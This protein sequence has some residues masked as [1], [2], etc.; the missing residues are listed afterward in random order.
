MDKNDYDEGI[1]EMIRQG[2]FEELKFSNGNPKSPL[3]EM[4]RN[5]SD[6]KK[7]VCDLT[8]DRCL[9]YRLTVSNLKVATLYGYALPKTPYIKTMCPRENWQ[10][11]NIR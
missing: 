6:C 1:V 3:N 10:N 4:D 8:G 9:I 5:A 11:I 2:P 7:L